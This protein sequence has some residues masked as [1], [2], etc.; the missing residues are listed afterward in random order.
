MFWRLPEF[1]E[2]LTYLEQRNFVSKDFANRFALLRDA[3]NRSAH[4][5]ATDISKDDFQKVFDIAKEFLSALQKAKTAGY[6]PSPDTSEDEPNN[7]S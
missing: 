7:G 1:K 3:R 5:A 6:S 4:S 2:L